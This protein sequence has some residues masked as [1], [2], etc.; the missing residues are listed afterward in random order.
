MTRNAIPFL[1]CALAAC[2]GTAGHSHAD[3]LQGALELVVENA[4]DLR[5][6]LDPLEA[7]TV[8]ILLRGHGED[9]V[10][11]LDSSMAERGYSLTH[12]RD[13][14]SGGV[15]LFFLGMPTQV[16]ASNSDDVVWAATKALWR[17]GIAFDGASGME[18]GLFVPAA[19]A[20]RA[21]GVLAGIPSVALCVVGAS[22]ATNGR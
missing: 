4:G 11:T 3:P 14:D 12:R 2:A 21:R 18:R 1:L 8:C 20:A 22:G 7:P 13:V 5:P 17:A 9:R 19:H 6:G 15:E 16:L 10:E